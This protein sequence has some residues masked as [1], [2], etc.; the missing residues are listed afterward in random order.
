[1][2]L[3][4]SEIRELPVAE[5]FRLVAGA[6]G[7]NRLVEHVNLLDFE[8]DTWEPEAKTPDGI[9]DQ[10]SIIVTSLLFAKNKPEKIYPVIRQLY[11]D[12]VSAIAVKEV[13]YKELPQDVL[14]FANEKGIPIFMFDSEAN[15]SENVVVGL[16]LAIDEH[17]NVDGLEEKILFLLQEN[18]GNINRYKLIEELF[19]NMNMPYQCF[20]FMEKGFH[21]SFSYHHR[22][23]SLRN[24]K[25]KNLII[26]PYQYGILITAFGEDTW[27]VAEIESRLGLT[28]TNHYCGISKQ[29]EKQQDIPYMIKQSVFA[30]NHARKMEKSKCHFTEMGILQLIL[31]NKDNYWIKEYCEEIANKLKSYDSDGSFELFNTM[32]AY[33]HNACDV[34]KTS[35]ELIL[36]KNTIRY[37]I[38]KAKEVLGL[39]NDAS[40]FNEIIFF[41]MHF[42]DAEE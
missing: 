33:V 25:E 11:I 26:L 6:S 14:S 27:S 22:I 30:C 18:L 12:G 28:S 36:H 31:P 32:K 2:A 9:F 13:Y 17:D 24:K 39:E 10:K 7:L 40:G 8:Y 4:I 21:S 34:N 42:L 5:D 37:R 1:M 35:E 19:P 15:Y 3:T 23:L 38:S 16:T 29:T 20:Y 41:V